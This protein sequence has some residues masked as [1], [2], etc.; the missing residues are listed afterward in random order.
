MVD[1]KFR[2]DICFSHWAPSVAQS[3]KFDSWQILI[4]PIFC[5]VHVATC[6]LFYYPKGSIITNQNKMLN[7]LLQSQRAPVE[8]KAPP[9]IFDSKKFGLGF[10]FECD[11]WLRNKTF[12][13]S[14]WLEMILP[15]GSKTNSASPGGKCVRFFLSTVMIAAPGSVPGKKNSARNGGCL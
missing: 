11:F 10:D 4:S 8:A 2:T 15:F 14:I 1:N 3:W 9:R 5:F 12:K 13:L 7:V 6:H